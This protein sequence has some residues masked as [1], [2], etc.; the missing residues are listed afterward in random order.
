MLKLL[1]CLFSAVLLAVLM[2]QLRQQRLE[3]NHQANKLH[4]Q[5]EAQQAKLWNQQLQIAV[6]T[7]PNAISKTVGE[8][9]LKLVP[10]SPLHVGPSNWMDVRGEPAN[11]N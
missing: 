11:H 5:I 3:L 1:L 7:A 6:Y 2:L 10:Q 8:K 9:D 4:N